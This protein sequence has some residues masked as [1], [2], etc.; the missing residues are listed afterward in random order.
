MYKPKRIDI[1]RGAATRNQS[2]FIRKCG[3]IYLEKRNYI[4]E[5]LY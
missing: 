1:R 4:E 5:M 3:D 2:K